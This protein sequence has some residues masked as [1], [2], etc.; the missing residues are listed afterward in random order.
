MERD[1]TRE[2]TGTRQDLVALDV[3]RNARARN[4][5]GG[6]PMAAFLTQLIVEA[7]PALRPSRSDRTRTAAARYAQAATRA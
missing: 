3:D 4:S 5:A 1:G 6:R 7:D 2:R